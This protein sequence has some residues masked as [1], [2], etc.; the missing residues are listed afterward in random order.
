MNS[1]CSP[2]ISIFD[3]GKICV[4]VRKMSH[5]KES[6]KHTISFIFI[7]LFDKYIIY[8]LSLVKFLNSWWIL[9]VDKS[10]LRIKEFGF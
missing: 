8:Y 6:T 1:S 3:K 7:D 10:V 9:K 2:I 5:G 4:I